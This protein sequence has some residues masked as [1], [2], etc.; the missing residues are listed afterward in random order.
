[1]LPGQATEGQSPDLGS[2]RWRFSHKI[3]TFLSDSRPAD[4]SGFNLV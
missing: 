1:L 3:E 2:K 4:R